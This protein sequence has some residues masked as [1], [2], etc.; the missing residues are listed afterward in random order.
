[1]K[2]VLIVPPLRNMI[3]CEY[4]HQEKVCYYQPIGLLYLAGYLKTYSEYEVEILD[5][6]ANKWGYKMLAK[7]LRKRSPDVVGIT[8]IT[9]YI[10][11][12]LKTADLVKKISSRIKVCLGGPHVSIYPYETICHKQVD[13]VIVGDGERKF[14]KLLS[15]WEKEEEKISIPGV[16]T[17]DNQKLSYDDYFI[18]E[19]DN[20]PFPDRDLVDPNKYRSMVSSSKFTTLLTSRGC[21]YSCTFCKSEKLRLRSPKNVIKEIVECAKNGYKIIEIYDETFNISLKRVEE[22]CKGIINHD[23]KINW[24]SRMRVDKINEN[25]LY[26]AKRSGCILISFGIESTSQQVLNRIK[27]GITLKQAE[28]AIRLCRKVGI[29]TCAN[30]MLGSPEETEEDIRNTINWVK[31]MEPDYVQYSI[32]RMLP[33]TKLYEEAI[34]ESLLQK[35]VWKKF[36]LSPTSDFDYPCWTKS[37]SKE[38][39]L[40]LSRKAQRNFYFNFKYLSRRLFSVSSIKKL[41]NDLKSGWAILRDAVF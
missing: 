16:L 7:E 2:V 24:M 13:A 8:A 27:K 30:F 4:P 9:H 22:I 15:A 37:I 21:P 28:Y 31:K 26:L 32:T 35:D 3:Y 25:M 10:Y 20:L 34:K 23:L 11:D 1:M 36:A 33:G 19:L 29:E 5:S 39:L 38:R 14:F 6:L 41:I 17:K 18:E 40:L 12:A